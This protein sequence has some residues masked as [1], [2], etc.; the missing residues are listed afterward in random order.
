MYAKLFARITESSL[1]EEP[2]NVR[3]T[4]M[5]MLAIADPEGYVIG[6]DVAIARRMNMSVPE[7]VQCIETLSQPDPA[8]NS[9]E[10]DGRR[11]IPSDGERG[12]KV[13]NYVTYRDM[14]DEKQRRDYMREYMRLYRDGK[15]PDKKR[16]PRKQ[17]L[18][19]LTQGEVPVEVNGK[20]GGHS[21]HVSEPFK[22]AFAKWEQHRI[23][24]K[25]PLKP[26]GR[27]AL[28]EQLSELSEQSAIEQIRKGIAGGWQ[29]LVFS[30]TPR[31]RSSQA[32]TD[33]W[34]A[35]EYFDFRA[36]VVEEYPR[37]DLNTSLDAVPPPMRQAYLSA[38]K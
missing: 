18:A 3:F 17:K 23:E 28:L 11:I 38:R 37:F 31:D 14:K 1:M 19:P 4:F 2:I 21:L 12:Y 5:L 24:I 22:K 15:Q 33:P 9:K 36:W 13:V 26:T 8:S 7:F 25:K 30:E 10:K 29:G 16:K 35:V 27:Q 34:A 6:T 20:E 32:P